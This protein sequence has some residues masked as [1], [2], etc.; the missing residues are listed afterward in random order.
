MLQQHS[1]AFGHNQH[2]AGP[3]WQEVTNHCVGAFQ[4]ERG[5]AATVASRPQSEIRDSK[6]ACT[7]ARERARARRG[8]DEWA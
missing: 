8:D 6:R 1:M 5:K 2:N 7:V 3:F 4:A